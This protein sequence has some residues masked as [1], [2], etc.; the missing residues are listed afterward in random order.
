MKL[1]EILTYVAT[2]ST[3]ILLAFLFTLLLFKGDNTNFIF[4]ACGIILVSLIVTAIVAKKLNYKLDIFAYNITD[5]KYLIINS[6]FIGNL[7]SIPIS[8]FISLAL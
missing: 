1:K 7:F 3:N 6:V 4:S 2:I 5:I 8:M